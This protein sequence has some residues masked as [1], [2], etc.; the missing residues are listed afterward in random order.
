LLFKAVLKEGVSGNHRKAFPFMFFKSSSKESPSPKG[1]LFVSVIEKL[2]K[3]PPMNYEFFR[4][5][6]AD[7]GGIKFF[8]SDSGERFKPRK[9]ES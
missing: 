8:W 5:R 4:G 3:S 6:L 2:I 1:F 7:F 9:S